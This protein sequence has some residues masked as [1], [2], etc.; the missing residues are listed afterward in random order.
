MVTIWASA[1]HGVLFSASCRS[2]GSAEAFLTALTGAHRAPLE[3]FQSSGPT[4]MVMFTY[5]DAPQ[6]QALVSPSYN[7]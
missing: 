2:S 4:E 1:S 5:S 7:S 6:K 3:A